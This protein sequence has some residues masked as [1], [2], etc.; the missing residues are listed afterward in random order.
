MVEVKGFPRPLYPPD[1]AE[2][3]KKPSPDGPDCLAYKRTV[4]RAGR[5]GE[6]DPNQWDNSYSNR[7]GHGHGPNVKDTGIA[8]VQRQQS[9]DDTGWIG[10]QTFNTLRSIRVPEGPHEGEMAMDAYAADL[11][12]KAFD[13]YA[14]TGPPAGSPPAR[15]L[16]AMRDL[17]GVHEQPAG[18]N[19][20]PGI[21]DWYGLDG[22]PWCAMA[23][24][25]AGVNAGLAAFKRGQRWHYV[26]TIVADARA[27]RYQLTTVDLGLAQPGDVV[28]FDWDWSDFASSSNHVGVFEKWTATGSAF[29][30][31]ESNVDSTTA[32]HT[33]YV[34]AQ[35]LEIVRVRG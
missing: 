13:L 31:I 30:T 1:A 18:S 24:T 21:T 9:I 28:C 7:F 26:P 8:G 32:R 29:Q 27:G 33:R 4:C 11:I 2:Q 15:L 20:V 10:E 23:V 6:W 12:D 22:Q 35:G 19:H 3:G 16:E 5:W 17:L 34:A 14:G 25:R